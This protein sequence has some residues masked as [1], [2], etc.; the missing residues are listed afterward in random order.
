[1]SK[2]DEKKYRIKTLASRSY[3]EVYV[4]EKKWLFWWFSIQLTSSYDW[5]WMGPASFAYYNHAERFLLR[6]IK[7][8]RR[9][10]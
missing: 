5:G 4:V 3:G 8:G 2:W 1:M 6:Y 9:M 7:T 10:I